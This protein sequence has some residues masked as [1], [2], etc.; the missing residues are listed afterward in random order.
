MSDV[1]EVCLPLAAI[2][3]TIANIAQA[4]EPIMS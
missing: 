1:I 4:G 3:T 2:V